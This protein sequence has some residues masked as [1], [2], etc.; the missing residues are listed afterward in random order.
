ML[1]VKNTN[2]STRYLNLNLKHLPNIYFLVKSYKVSGLYM[3][4]YVSCIYMHICA[5]SILAKHC[6]SISIRKREKPNM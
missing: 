6:N 3:S 5:I 4:M 1:N 2:F